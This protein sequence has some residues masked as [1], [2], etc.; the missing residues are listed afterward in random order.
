MRILFLPVDPTLAPWVHSHWSFEGPLG[1]PQDDR[2]VVVPHGRSRI[3]VPLEGPLVLG[4]GPTVT[5]FPPGRPLFVGPW[6]RPVVLSSPPGPTRTLGWEFTP[7]GAYRFFDLPLTEGFNRVIP[8]DDLWPGVD[9][10]GDW[11]GDVLA[12]SRCLQG[13]LVARARGLHRAQPVVD[14]LVAELERRAGLVKMDELERLTGYTRRTLS[15]LVQDHVGLAP[16][17]L[18]RVVRFQT[19]YR[20]WARWGAPLPLDLYFDQS[21]FI[22]EFKDFTGT[23]PTRFT[24]ESNRFGRLFYTRSS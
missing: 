11:R 12:A 7:A 18:A 21:H 24:P 13:H 19:V 1:L 9:Q 15:T 10:T 3:I 6:D 4:D 17:T 22:R 23:T 20:A 8:L 16:K 14:F 2:R 5:S